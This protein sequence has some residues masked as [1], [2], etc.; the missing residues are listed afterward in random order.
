M[1]RPD[2]VVNLNAVIPPLFFGHFLYGLAYLIKSKLLDH[3]P[4][5]HREVPQELVYDVAIISRQ[6]VGSNAERFTAD[7][8]FF[9]RQNGHSP[10]TKQS[11]R[12][13]QLRG[14]GIEITLD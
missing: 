10:R 9:I 3:L 1:V 12:L 13:V 4:N 8:G 5:G 7:D 11:A 2:V 14:F 6:P